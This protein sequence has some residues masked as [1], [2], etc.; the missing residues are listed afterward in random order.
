MSAVVALRPSSEGAEPGAAVDPQVVARVKG[1]LASAGFEVLAPFATSFSVGAKT[2]LFAQVFGATV[3]VDEDQL[4]AQVHIE[5]GGHELPLD[6]LPD[7]V[8][9]AV[10]SISFIPPPDFG[11]LA[12]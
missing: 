4:P 10:E 9:A 8:R 12:G 11:S 7:D 5:G 1:H 2:S 6:P 3:V